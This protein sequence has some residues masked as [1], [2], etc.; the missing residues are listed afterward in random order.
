[1]FGELT[2]SQRR[3][4]VA[5]DRAAVGRRS[6]RHIRLGQEFESPVSLMGRMSDVIDVLDG[7]HPRGWVVSDDAVDD[8]LAGVGDSTK[9]EVADVQPHAAGQTPSFLVSSQVKSSSRFQ[10]RWRPIS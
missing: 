4:A 10:R 6:L 8:E 7:G 9:V 5:A 1:M 2:G 3:V